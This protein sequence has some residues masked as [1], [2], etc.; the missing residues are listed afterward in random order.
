MDK[1]RVGVILSEPFAPAW[2]T[3]MLEQIRDSSH[4]GV[5][6]LAFA[7]EPEEKSDWAGNFYKFHFQLDKRIYRPGSDPWERKDVRRLLQNTQISGR[8]LKELVARLK[9]MRL[10]ILLNLSLDVLPN[11]LREVARF[12]VWSLRCNDARITTKMDAGWHEILRGESLMHCSVDIQRDESVQGVAESVMAVHPYSVTCNQ[13]SLLWRASDIVPRALK[14]LFALGERE[15]F[16][17]AKSVKLADTISRPTPGQIIS[18]AWKQAGRTLENKIWRRWFPHRWMLMAGSAR[19]EKKFD[20]GGVKPLVPPRGAYWADP[21]LFEREGR[22]YIFFEEY[23]YKN[24]LG[25]IS[26]FEIENGI[27]TSQPQVV[28]ERPYHLSYPFIFGYR[29]EFYMIP[30]TAQKRAIEVYRCARVPDRW[31]YHTTLMQDVRALDTTLI[32]HSA[33]WWMF[34]NIAGEGGSA[35]DE[36]HLFHADDPLS[37]NWTPH[38]MNP[39]VSDVRSAR[40]AGRIFRRDGGLVRPSQDSSHRY[41]YAVNLN[42]ITRL[43]VNEYEEELIERIEP[44]Q[45]GRI[46]AVHTYNHSGSLLVLDALLKR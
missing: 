5:T 41:G 2:V 1:L 43:T 13:A 17:G 44:P 8:D 21:F 42:R 30:E 39:I 18:L 46:L 23:I 33:R 32:E 26:F 35:W 40:P 16:S 14:Q 3:R 25:R 24:K 10:D 20:W 11:S 36:L 9:A 22:T 27:P 7:N 37:T 15:F 31:E 6:T 34:V 29:G 12:G 19:L 38:P 45:T 4:A 28:L